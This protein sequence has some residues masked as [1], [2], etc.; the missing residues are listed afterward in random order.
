MVATT[1]HFVVLGL[2]AVALL[3]SASPVPSNIALD[4][5]DVS[6]DDSAYASSLK[7]SDCEKL[8]RAASKNVLISCK[9]RSKCISKGKCDPYTTTVTVGGNGKPS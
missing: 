6:I 3:V 5:R 1:S 9:S 7:M 2:A 4:A 8:A